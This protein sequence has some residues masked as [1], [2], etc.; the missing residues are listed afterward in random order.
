METH[1]LR[2]PV[3][4]ECLQYIEKLLIYSL[5]VRVSGLDLVEKL[6]G[7]VE[8]SWWLVFDGTSVIQI[9][10]EG[11]LGSDW[12]AWG[13]C[14]VEGE[15][16]RRKLIGMR[17]YGTGVYATDNWDNGVRRFHREGVRSSG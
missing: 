6:Y 7:V 11:C 10:Q 12:N 5:V 8:L 9:T 2:R 13:V 1:I 16:W 14:P 15:R 4:L 3:F 17:R